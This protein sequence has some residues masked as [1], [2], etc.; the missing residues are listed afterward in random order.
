MPLTDV[1]VEYK[2]NVEEKFRLCISFLT[3][4]FSQDFRQKRSKM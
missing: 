3:Y 1:L 2:M 4:S